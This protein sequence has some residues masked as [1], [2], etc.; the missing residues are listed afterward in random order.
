MM[1][2]GGKRAGLRACLTFLNLSRAAAAAANSTST[3]APAPIFPPTTNPNHLDHVTR[4]ARLAA[5]AASA[6]RPAAVARR[7]A[8]AVAPARPSRSHGAVC[9]VAFRCAPPSSLARPFL[10]L[11]LAPLTAVPHA[12]ASP[13]DA[14]PHG[15]PLM[16]PP[17]SHAPSTNPAMPTARR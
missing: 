6:R 2:W 10:E 16:P 9:V 11:L 3:Q 8:A 17:P 5:P 12:L 4:K 1:I 13:L 14:Q 15:P 7:A